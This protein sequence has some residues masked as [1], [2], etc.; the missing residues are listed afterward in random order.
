MPITSDCQTG[1]SNLTKPS[2]SLAGL[3]LFPSIF[4]RPQFSSPKLPTQVWAPRPLPWLRA[5]IQQHCPLG[6]VFL[7]HPLRVTPDCCLSRQHHLHVLMCFPSVSHLH[8][9]EALMTKSTQLKDETVWTLRQENLWYNCFRT[10]E[11]GSSN[12]LVEV[13]PH[14]L[15]IQ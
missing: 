2:F 12:L 10:N 8:F 11:P 5:E 3:H 15:H 13:T 14:A 9:Q 1:H 4:M 6:L 7:P